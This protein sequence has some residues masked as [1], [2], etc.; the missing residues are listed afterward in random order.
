MEGGRSRRRSPT[1]NSESMSLCAELPFVRSMGSYG[2]CWVWSC[3]EIASEPGGF[4]GVG[5]MGVWECR[6]L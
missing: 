4:G 3:A 1:R 5:E 6:C 2:E